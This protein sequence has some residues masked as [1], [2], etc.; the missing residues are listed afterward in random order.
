MA[1]GR[2]RHDWSIASALM[3]LIANLHRDPKKH[4]ALKPRDFDP[5]SRAGSATSKRHPKV[6]VSILKEVF[7]DGKVPLVLKELEHD[8]ATAPPTR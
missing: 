3:T 2:Q 4:R 7:I 1:E 5:F 8:A 6:P